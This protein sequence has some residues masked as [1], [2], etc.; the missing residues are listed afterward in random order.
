MMKQFFYISKHFIL[1]F[2]IEIE[3]WNR[4]WVTKTGTYRFASDLTENFVKMNPATS[5]AF[6]LTKKFVKLNTVHNL[7]CIWFDGK[8]RKI[9]EYFNLIFLWFNRKFVKLNNAPCFAFDLT[10]KFVEVN[11]TTSHCSGYYCKKSRK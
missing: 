10:E 11:T 3:F 6:D 9:T 1:S 4:K 8:I 5:F 7:I 2:R